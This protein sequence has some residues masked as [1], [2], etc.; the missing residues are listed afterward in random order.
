[1]EFTELIKKRYSVR[2]FKNT[3]IKKETIKLIL[4]AGRLAPTAT[5]SQPQRILVMES[6]ESLNKL[7]LC[8]TC[9]FDA[10]LALLIC[11]DKESSWRRK[12]DNYDMGV[13]DASI[14]VTHMMLQI[15]N[16][17]LGSTWVGH[18]NPKLIIEHFSL[19]D[20]F[21]PVAI[22]PIGYL[23]TDSFPS[24]THDIRYSL[25]HTVFYESF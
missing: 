10:P 19:P 15:A 25:D 6:D 1:M 11:Y 9:H 12:Y 14:V 20:N 8:T 22:L 5:N 2:K 17:G 23:A 21:L 7:K 13:V 16:L 4:E 3:K 24:P 18:F